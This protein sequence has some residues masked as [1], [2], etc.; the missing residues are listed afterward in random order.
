VQLRCDAFY[1]LWWQCYAAGLAV[2]IPAQYLLARRPLSI[3]FLKLFEGDG[4]FAVVARDR[5]GREAGVNAV[6]GGPGQVS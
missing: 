4:V 5:G 6:E 3:A 1:L 2:E